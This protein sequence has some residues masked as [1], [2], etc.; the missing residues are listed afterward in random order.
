MIKIKKLS[1]AEVAFLTHHNNYM[2]NLLNSRHQT[3]YLTY[4]ISINTQPM[5]GGTLS[6]SCEWDS[7]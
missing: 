6:P 1:C 4:N 2:Y 7:L 3:K 5:E